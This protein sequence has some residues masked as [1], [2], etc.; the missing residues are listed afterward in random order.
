MC[1]ILPAGYKDKSAETIKRQTVKV[2][3]LLIAKTQKCHKKK[4]RMLT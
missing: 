1:K 2:L 3:K 4:L